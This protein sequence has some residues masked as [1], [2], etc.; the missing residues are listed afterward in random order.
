MVQENFVALA[1][2]LTS[3]TSTFRAHTVFSEQVL[4]NE[5]L[6]LLIVVA[7]VA[8]TPGCI[9]IRV[10]HVKQRLTRVWPCRERMSQLPA[11]CTE[12]VP[13]LAYTT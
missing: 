4:C 3:V 2:T 12:D 7:A 5:D 6:L 11:A 1:K 9:K 13:F 8:I 10:T